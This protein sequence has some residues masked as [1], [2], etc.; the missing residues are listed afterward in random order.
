MVVAPASEL[1]RGAVGGSRPIIPDEDGKSSSACAE[2]ET[3][4]ST[5]KSVVS[6]V[7]RTGGICSLR[8]PHRDLSGLTVS[9]F[10]TKGLAC[11][12]PCGGNALPYEL[13]GRHRYAGVRVKALGGTLIGRG[14]WMSTISTLSVNGAK[15][16]V[17]TRLACRRRPGRRY[18]T[19]TSG[20]PIPAPQDDLPT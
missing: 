10:Y 3:S 13:A 7:G 14:V 4:T 16:R 1:L 15:R 12:E 5:D 11:F 9:Q 8:N 6:T 2:G 17:L 19:L 20:S 18:G